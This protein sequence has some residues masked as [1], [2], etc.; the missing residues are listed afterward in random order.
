MR[1]ARAFLG[2]LRGGQRATAIL[3][4]DSPLRPNWS[5]LPERSTRFD[6]NGLRLGDLEPD[7]LA[8][9]FGFLAAALSK[10][11][12]KTLVEV[13]GAEAVLEDSLLAVFVGWSAENYW[14][15]FFG[16]PTSEGPWGWQ[17][18][19][20]H[21]ALNGTV[22]RGRV[23]SLSPTFVGVE[24]A[25][26][27]FAG[28]AGRPLSG[29][30]SDGVALIRSLPDALRDTALVPW[31]PRRLHAGAGRD[32][33]IPDIEGSPVRDWPEDARRKLLALLRHWVTL[34]PDEN[35]RPRMQALAAELDRMH[36]AW[37]GDPSLADALYYRIQGP[38][39]IVEFATQG[40]IGGD[41]HYHSVYRNPANEYGASGPEGTSAPLR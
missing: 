13:V 20:H 33:V 35:A 12:Y 37:K 36:F 40:D 3:P 14:I 16:H 6:R 34:Q 18:G 5:N 27:E 24:P 8:A 41:G 38:S 22:H 9:A 1:A 28:V 21:L 15:A 39:L 31:R 2:A 32:G 30:L 25:E 11:G 10:H 29:E 4:Y 7:Q 19:G 26:F 23:V 17:F